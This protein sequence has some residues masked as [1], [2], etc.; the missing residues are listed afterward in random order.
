MNL[1]IKKLRKAL[2]LTQQAFAERIGVKQN[3][4]AL[5]ESGKRNTSD[6]LLLG[7]CREFK[8]SETWLRTG[9]GEM[10]IK[11]TANDEISAFVDLA[12]CDEPGNIRYRFLSALAAMS[13]EELQAAARFALALAK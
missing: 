5:I 9:K 3:T 8:I 11:R 6:Q 1:R 10:F 4:I 12:L 7:V 13:E 2:D